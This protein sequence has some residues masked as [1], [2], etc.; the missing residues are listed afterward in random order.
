MTIDNTQIMEFIVLFGSLGI[1]SYGIIFYLKNPKY[2]Y[3]SIGMV[4]LGGLFT[5]MSL[6]FFADGSDIICF[7][8]SSGMIFLLIF[9]F[10]IG[11]RIKKETAELWV[12]KYK[13]VSKEDPIKPS[14][15]MGG[16]LQFKL[17]LKKGPDYTAKVWAFIYASFFTV[18]ISVIRFFDGYGFNI[19]GDI[20]T[21]IIVF[22]IGYFISKKQ[23]GKIHNKYLKMKDEGDLTPKKS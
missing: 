1:F 3:T 10:A 14:D 2:I 23:F 17:V 21:F 5:V 7:L 4:V 19:Y 18:L 9:S 15:F 6:L 16:K 20:A 13:D 8:F 11:E 12:E 22:I